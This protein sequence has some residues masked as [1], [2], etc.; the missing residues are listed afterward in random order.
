MHR[1]F[2]SNIAKITAGD[3]RDLVF[4]NPVRVKTRVNPDF[5]K[6]TVVEDAAASL[7]K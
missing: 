6:G 2:V 1:F 4:V 5:F 7:T 3:F